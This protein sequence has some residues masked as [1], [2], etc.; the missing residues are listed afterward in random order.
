MTTTSSSLPSS[1][2]RPTTT[3]PVPMSAGQW[4]PRL[5]WLWVPQLLGAT[6][7]WYLVDRVLNDRVSFVSDS[8]LLILAVVVL[9]VLGLGW[10]IGTMLFGAALMPARTWRW[11]SAL[12]SSLAIWFF[13]PLQLWTGLAWVVLL[14][15]L[16]VGIEQAFDHAHNSLLVRTRQ[17]IGISLGFPLLM[18]MIATSLLYYQQLRTSTDTPDVLASNVVDQSATTVERFLPRVR[19]DYRIGM[20]VDEL[21][22]LFIPEA[23][24]VLDDITSDGGQLSSDEQARLREQ[25]AERGVPIEDLQLDYSQTEEQLRVALDQQIDQFR[26]EIVANLR[27][28]LSTTLQIELQGDDAVQAVLQTYFG[29]QFDRYVRDYLTWLPPLLA[30][31]LFFTLRLVSIIFQWAIIMIGWIWSKILRWTNVIGIIHETVPAERL[32]WNK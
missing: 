13:L 20:T 18:L 27:E 21:L 17:V 14:A 4:T 9:G 19:S 28:E 30:L 8:G 32:S 22:G 31:A 2:N 1:V 6:L 10:W 7:W 5:L 16:V 26:S 3:G 11:L 29:R 24:D 12:V 23:G 15:G 25:L